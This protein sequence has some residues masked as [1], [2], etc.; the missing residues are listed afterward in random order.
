M[1]VID[2]GPYGYGEVTAPTVVTARPSRRLPMAM[3]NPAARWAAVAV[4]C[5]VGEAGS[6][7]PVRNREARIA[8]PYVA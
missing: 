5:K 4:W 6:H 8:V 3:K 7:K 2:I 1:S